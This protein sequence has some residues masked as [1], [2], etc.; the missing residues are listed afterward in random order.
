MDFLIRAEQYCEQRG[1]DAVWFKDLYTRY[2]EN[3]SVQDSVWMALCY[4]YDET[5]A[6]GLEQAA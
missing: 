1:D 5:I 2:R 6:A 4:L 3:H